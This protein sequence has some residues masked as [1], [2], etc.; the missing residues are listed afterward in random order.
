MST[1]S[2]FLKNTFHV[3]KACAKL[4]QGQPNPWLS[5]GSVSKITFC[6]QVAVL[7]SPTKPDNSNWK[8]TETEDISVAT[9]IVKI[10]RNAWTLRQMAAPSTLIQQGLGLWRG[11]W[12]LCHWKDEVFNHSLILLVRGWDTNIF[13]L[14]CTSTAATVKIFFINL[15]LGNQ[16]C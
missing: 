11:Q 4:L 6:F 8:E 3:Y 13:W 7:F 15:P 16:S 9:N 12:E 14:F 5:C 1:N 2:S 10:E